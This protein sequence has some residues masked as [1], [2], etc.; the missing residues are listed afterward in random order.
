MDWIKMTPS[1]MPEKN[2]RVI[3][4]TRNLDGSK[5][6]DVAKWCGEKLGWM[7]LL[8]GFHPSTLETES[9]RF[10]ITHWMPYPEAAED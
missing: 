10:E 5:T 3:L 9:A 2:K 7:I 1:T 8:P 4:T 6:T